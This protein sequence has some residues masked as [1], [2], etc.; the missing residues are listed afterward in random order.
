MHES[1]QEQ[2]DRLDPEKRAKFEA[3][4]ARWST[5][6]YRAEEE[7]AREA[8]NRE[9]TETGTI[10]TEPAGTWTEV[11][12]MVRIAGRLRSVREARGLSLD[13]VA[14]VMGIE[15]SEVS[16]LER[17]KTNP[18]LRTLLRY[19]QAIGMKLVVDVVEPAPVEV[20][21]TSP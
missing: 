4:I 14:A 2:L 13:D 21:A 6:E 11:K 17:G 1:N 10:A 12:A 5:P 7:A 20:S 9:W 3:A 8:L 16:K 19:A 18:E 15:R